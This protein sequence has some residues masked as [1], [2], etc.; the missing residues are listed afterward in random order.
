[1]SKKDL[2]YEG[3]LKA[4]SE[5]E[6]SETTMDYIAEISS[7]AK[8]T[9]YYHFQTKEDLFIY[10]MKKGIGKLLDQVHQV[11]RE[12]YPRDQMLVELLKIHLKFY[13]EEK[14]FCQLLLSKIWGTQTKRISTQD[15]LQDYFDTM[16][17]LFRELQQEGYISGDID[18][19]TL[20]SSLFGMIGYTALRR[21][22]RGEEVYTQEV[23]RSLIKLCRGVLQFSQLP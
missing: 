9:L 16:E 7:V 1:M 22:I 12:Q 13:Q 6:F 14:Q 4:F 15:M 19:P 18:I 21:I 5:Q 2:I 20:T 8:G 3:A 23:K 10:V 11:I 17:G